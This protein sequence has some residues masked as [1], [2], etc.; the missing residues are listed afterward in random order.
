MEV[1][2]LEQIQGVGTLGEVVNVARG[3]ARN[4]LLPRNKALPARKE[5]M[6]KFEAERKEREA[7]TV[8]EK[9][10][11]EEASVKFTDLS[12]IIK[13]QASEVGMLYGSV[14]A[15]DIEAVL[16]EKGLDVP[17]ANIQIG[18]P[19][20]EVGTHSVQIFLHPEVTVTIT[21]DVARQTLEL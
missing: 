19:I 10:V 1:I 13:R 14:K 9:S 18:K 15:R 17:R 3:F 8:G 7:K 4:F 6:A 20:K 5:N 2:L 12:V 16:A 11:A 21:V